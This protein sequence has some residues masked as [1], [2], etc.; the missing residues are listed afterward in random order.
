MIEDEEVA[1][2]TVI[3]GK[4]VA[5]HTQEYMDGTVSSN[6]TIRTLPIDSR[7]KRRERQTSLK[8]ERV[9]TKRQLHTTSPL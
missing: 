3:Q 6:T 1:A 9:V 7:T 4:G 8:F 2:Y 5:V